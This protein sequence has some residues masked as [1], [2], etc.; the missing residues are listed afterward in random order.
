LYLKLI[1]RSKQKQAYS[2][3][4]LIQRHI[5]EIR[6]IAVGFLVV[7]LI[8]S[9]VGVLDFLGTVAEGVGNMDFGGHHNDHLWC[10]HRSVYSFDPFGPYFKNSTH[11]DLFLGFRHK[12]KESLCR[13]EAQAYGAFPNTCGIY[14]FLYFCPNNNSCNKN[15][16]P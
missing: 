14:T 16:T 7:E 5:I 13:I 3:Y 2:S 6:L 8:D 15:T 9:H 12:E 4:K 11:N 1:C 10:K